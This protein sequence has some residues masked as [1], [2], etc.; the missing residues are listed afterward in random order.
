MDQRGIFGRTMWQ[1]LA[2]LLVV[3]FAAVLLA[4]AAASCLIPA[5]RASRV[6]VA[7]LLR[8]E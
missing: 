4:A 1:S 2:M 3:V 7:R 5:R 8:A 6:D